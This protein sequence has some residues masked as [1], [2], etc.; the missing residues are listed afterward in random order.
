MLNSF[1]IWWAIQ[2]GQPDQMHCVALWP[3]Q[4]E[5]QNKLSKK[6]HNYSKQ[7]AG[8]ENIVMQ[9][10]GV[11]LWFRHPLS[12]VHHPLL[13]VSHTP[14]P[15]VKILLSLWM[16]YFGHVIGVYDTSVTRPEE[17]FHFF[18]CYQW[19]LWWGMIHIEF[20][21]CISVQKLSYAKKVSLKK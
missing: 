9:T 16:K 21:F 7:G 17:G 15:S 18:H 6:C 5:M 19:Q 4:P 10:E 3:A 11:D 2:P 12:Y 14:S 20:P 8:S 1:P 13:K